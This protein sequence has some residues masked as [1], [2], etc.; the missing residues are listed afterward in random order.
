MLVPS[1][2]QREK[3]S[4]ENANTF[5]KEYGKEMSH[6]TAAGIGAMV[7]FLVFSPLLFAD[8]PSAR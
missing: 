1:G 7:I 4:S 3:T 8:S 5:G 6:E 2:L